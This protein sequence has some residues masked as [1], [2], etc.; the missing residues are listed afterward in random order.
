MFHVQ[1]L[2]DDLFIFRTLSYILDFNVRSN[3]N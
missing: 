2:N 1:S 3:E